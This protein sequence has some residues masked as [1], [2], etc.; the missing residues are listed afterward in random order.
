MRS[1]PGNPN[2]KPSV[3]LKR[4]CGNRRC[5]ACRR[6]RDGLPDAH[7]W[8]A[9]PSESRR[10]VYG[11][12]GDVRFAWRQ[13]RRSP[14]F[15]AIAIL[16]LGVGAGAAT[17]I[18]STVYAVVLRP[19]PYR[20]PQQLV[21]LW[22]QNREKGLPREHLSPV[23]FL[24][25]RGTRAAFA[26]AAAWWRPDIN[27]ADPGLEP[28]RVNA[29]EVSANLFQLLGVSTQLGPGFPADGPFYSTRSHCRHQRSI[30]ARALLPGSRYRWKT[31]ERQVRPIPNRWSDAARVHVSRRGRCVVA[32]ELG[33]QPA[34]PGG[35]FH[36]S[37]RAVAARCDRGAS[38]LGAFATER[39]ARHG[40]CRDQQRL[41][42]L[43]DTAPRRHARILP[44]RD[45]RLGWRRHARAHHGVPQR[46][47][48]SA[49][50]RRAARTGIRGA[51]GAWGV[52][53]A[54][55]SPDAG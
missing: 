40:E 19:L 11:L 25:Y 12:A 36:G 39:A 43:S 46:R 13:L 27:V 55:R 50:A 20:D 8:S 16:T 51:I 37:R 45:A 15:A 44:G 47:Q 34:Q 32:L 4:R 52:S 14:S 31:V 29:I 7:A 33:S 6:H 17:A 49:R 5:R 28:V 1:Q 42:R 10:G 41:E 18:F 26:D 3:P 22:E 9:G 23:N 21:M 53:D 30:L 54:S 48:S 38:G 35:A 24:D 2:A